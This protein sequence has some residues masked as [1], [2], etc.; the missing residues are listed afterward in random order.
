MTSQLKL[1]FWRLLTQFRT[2]NNHQLPAWIDYAKIQYSIRFK[3]Y[4]AIKAPERSMLLLV[5]EFPPQIL[6]GVYRPISWIKYAADAGW[7]VTVLC[8]Q[9][10]PNPSE[11]GIE[12]ERSIPKNTQINRVATQPQ[13]PHPWPLPNIDGGLKN[14]FTV[15]ESVQPL[16]QTDRP[17]VILAS[18]PPFHNFLAGA[19]LAK[20]YNCPLVLDYRD[21]WTASPFTFV[22]KDR[23]NSKLEKYCLHRA[24]LV[25]FTTESQRLY[26]IQTFP[27][28]NEEKC[29]VVT[30]GWEPSD[31]FIPGNAR[32]PEKTINTHTTITIAYLGNLG[33]M[34]DP[35]SFLTALS[36]VLDAS[37]EIRTR[38]KFKC[39]GKKSTEAQKQLANFKYQDNLELIDQITKQ[40]ACQVM[41]SVDFLLILNPPTI[42][43]YIQGK[44]YEYI[45]SGTP[46][47]M[48]GKGGE[49]ADIISSLNTGIIVD[50]DNESELA[51]ALNNT[52]AQVRTEQSAKINNW[53]KSRQRKVLASI[54]FEHLDRVV[55]QRTNP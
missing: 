3:K 8:S 38:I 6:G 55:Q 11:A 41:R 45:A 32:P 1:V 42:H 50:A 25:I 18:G 34:A 9:A 33:P 52:N 13:G 10:E 54:I 49:M 29:V 15:F 44:L 4:R 27:E 24:D 53:L 37:P 17:G 31:F 28:L 23:I 40:A 20:K 12:L 36:K 43:R 19:W 46:I 21:E 14:A 5:W 26:A 2:L 7:K 51:H 16:M 22:L 48:F 39:I 47:L 35:E 30:N